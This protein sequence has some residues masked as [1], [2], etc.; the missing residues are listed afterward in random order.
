MPFQYLD[1]VHFNGAN[2]SMT[3]PDN[4]YRRPFHGHIDT[5]PD[6]SKV[7]SGWHRLGL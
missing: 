6:H 2:E 7:L 1:Q 4:R 3:L 5:R